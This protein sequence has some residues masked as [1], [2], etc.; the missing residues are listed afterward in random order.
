[1]QIS[2]ILFEWPGN[3]QHGFTLNSKLLG[4]MCMTEHGWNVTGM[5]VP[6]DTL[7]QTALGRM[8]LMLPAS[9]ER[10]VPNNKCVPLVAPSQS[11]L[12]KRKIR[13]F[14]RIWIQKYARIKKNDTV[15]EEEQQQRLRQYVHRKWFYVGPEGPDDTHMVSIEH[16]FTFRNK[17]YNHC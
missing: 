4:L 14:L 11:F 8:R 3:C 16:K 10:K 1:M 12:Y 5:D 6:D 15:H 17:A 7:S 9:S 13:A 2:Q